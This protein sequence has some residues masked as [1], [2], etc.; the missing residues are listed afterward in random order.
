MKKEHFD[1]LAE[2]LQQALDYKRGNR[3]AAR[4]V[5]RVIDIPEYNPEE[6]AAV[7]LKLN[8]TQ[9]GL[10]QV[11]GVSPRTVEAWEAGANKPNGSARHLLYLLGKDENT[12]KILLKAQ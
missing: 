6:I 1:L 8:L 5:V 10:A 4:S 12:L 2:S 11:V 9:R 3:K 7:R